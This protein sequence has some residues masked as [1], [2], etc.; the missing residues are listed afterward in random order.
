MKNLVIKKILIIIFVLFV[1]I[2]FVYL[3]DY[4]KNKKNIENNKNNIDFCLDDKECV[5]E[6]CCHS[7]SCVNVL[8]KPNC[9]EIMCTQECSSILDCGYGRC[10]CINN[11]CKAV[12]N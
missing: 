6:N 3:I 7:D 2:G 8:Y 5:P 12:K 10:A 1:I 11:K 9:R 4:F